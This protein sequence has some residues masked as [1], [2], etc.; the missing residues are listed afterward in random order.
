MY[1]LLGCLLPV[2]GA[3]GPIPK[4]PG[5]QLRHPEPGEGPHYRDQLVPS[6]SLPRPIPKR[7]EGQ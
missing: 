5:S 3:L 4:P 1:A 6:Q 2:Q 7:P